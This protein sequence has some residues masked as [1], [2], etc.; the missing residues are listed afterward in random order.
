MDLD[1][2]AASAAFR[3]EAREWLAA[4][5]RSLPSMDTA[6]GFAAHREWE[7]ELAEARW[8]VVSWPREYHGRDAS[9]LQWLLFEEEYYASGAPGRVSQ[10]GIFMLGPTLFAHGTPE[11]RDRILPAM[12]TG[13]QVWAQAW[14]EPEAGS[15]IAALRST[16]VRTDGGWRLSGQK[17]WSSRATF[18][19]RAFGLFRTDPDAQRHQGLTYFMA[20]LRAEGVTVRPIPQL[21]GEPGFAEIF[22]DDVF[23][24]DEDVIGEVGQG[25]RVAMTTAN[26]E[27]GLSLRSPGRFLAAADRLVDLWRDNGESPSTRD[28]VAD[29]WIGARAYR[30]YTF[31]T[32]SRLADGGELGPESSVNKLFWSHLDV[33][34]HETALD[35]LGPEA[36]TNPDWVDGYLFSLAGPIY[37]GTDQIQRNTIAERLL[38]LPREARR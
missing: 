1:I 15:D 34:L 36:E 6:E 4:H 18:A 3:D 11:Q 16:A 22:F 29:A 19:D 26:N 33:E 21:D 32:V 8:S 27:R 14:S 30:L 7:A 23:V 2:D 12:A 5:V 38:K 28:R 37:G 20:D 13:E 31:G 10:N 17:T 25:W 9:M 24:P 35:V